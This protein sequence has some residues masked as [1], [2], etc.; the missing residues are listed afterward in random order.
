MFFQYS[1]SRSRLYRYQVLILFSGFPSM[2]TTVV[3]TDQLEDTLQGTEPRMVHA[4]A[5]KSFLGTE[6]TFVKLPSCVHVQI[7][8]RQRA[9]DRKG[10]ICVINGTQCFFCAVLTFVLNKSYWAAAQFYISVKIMNWTI[11]N[12]K[13][14]QNKCSLCLVQYNPKQQRKINS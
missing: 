12:A 11:L 1:T 9:C 2:D 14:K 7:C 4:M 10:V 13:H 8:R 5:G 3:H 6:D